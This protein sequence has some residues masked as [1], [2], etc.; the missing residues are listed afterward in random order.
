MVSNF[1]NNLKAFFA[2]HARAVFATLNVDRAFSSLARVDL[3]NGNLF[4]FLVCPGAM[5]SMI[6][7]CNHGFKIKDSVGSAFR[8]SSFGVP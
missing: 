5:V 4:H 3:C 2:L 1:P 6:T 8:R 7:K